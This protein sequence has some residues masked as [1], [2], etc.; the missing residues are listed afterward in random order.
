MEWMGLFSGFLGLSFGVIAFALVRA[1]EEKLTELEAGL[2][3][4]K[5]ELAKL[6]DQ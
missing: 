3:S 1:Q 2:Q 6:R 4:V 5:E